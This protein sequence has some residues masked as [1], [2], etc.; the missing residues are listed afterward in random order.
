MKVRKEKYVITFL[1]TTLVFI[2]GIMIGSEITRARVESIQQSLQLDVLESQSLEIELSILN[3]F[4][5]KEDMCAYIESRL[6]DIAKKKV[7]IGRRFDIGDVPKDEAELLASQFIVSLGRYFVFNE[8]QT[9]ECKLTKPTVLFFPD[10]SEA[11][12]E[13][14]KVLDNIVFRLGDVNIT[15][16]TFNSIFKEKQG[17][18]KM[19]YNLNNVTKTPTIMIKGTKYEGFQEMEKVTGILC[20]NYDLAIC[21]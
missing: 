16:F 8:I 2:I 1:L 21:K 5:K 13:Q 20:G 10:T 12:R 4:G 3:Q 18:V 15:V 6:P 11:S 14:A 17:I 7:E 9:E 19:V